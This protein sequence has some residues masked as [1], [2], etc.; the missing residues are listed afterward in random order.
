VVTW[1]GMQEDRFRIVKGQEQLVRFASSASAWRGFCSRCGS[2]MLFG[3][4]RWPGEVHVA[5]ANLEGELD[6]A[7]VANVYWDVHVPWIEGME[8]LIKLGGETGNQPLS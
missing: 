5:L 7:P 4:D 3:G 8:Q 1:F 2:T 6:R